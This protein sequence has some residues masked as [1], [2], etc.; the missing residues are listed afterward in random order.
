MMIDAPEKDSI[1][2]R[3]LSWN[4]LRMPDSRLFPLVSRIHGGMPTEFHFGLSH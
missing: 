1:L 3:H 2:I 4:L